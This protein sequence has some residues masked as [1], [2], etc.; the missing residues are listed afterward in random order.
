[1]DDSQQNINLAIT[2][3]KMTVELYIILKFFETFSRTYIKIYFGIQIFFL[4][5]YLQ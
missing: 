4:F 3:R 1:M 2:L 5:I